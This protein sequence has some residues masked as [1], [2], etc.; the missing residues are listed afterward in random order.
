MSPLQRYSQPFLGQNVS[1]KSVGLTRANFALLEQFCPWA[2]NALGAEQKLPSQ[3]D[4]GKICPRK[5]KFCP[6]FRA[7]SAQVPCIFFKLR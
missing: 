7:D 3:F 5:G 2:N 6:K 4:E 1:S